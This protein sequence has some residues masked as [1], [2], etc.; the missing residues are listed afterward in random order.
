MK[1]ILVALI[2][3]IL[4]GRKRPPK[5]SGLLR[6]KRDSQSSKRQRRSPKKSRRISLI[7]QGN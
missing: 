5:K 3:T 7:E 1:K 6:L 2:L 4:L